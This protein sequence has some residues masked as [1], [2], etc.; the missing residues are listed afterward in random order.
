LTNTPSDTLWFEQASECWGEFLETG[1]V[2]SLDLLVG[3]DGVLK[4]AFGENNSNPS[5][6]GERHAGST[7]L[8]ID[9]D[10]DNDQDLLMG[11]ISF[12]N[13]IYLEND[14]NADFAL[15]ME[16]EQHFPKNNTPV[17]IS[18]FPAAYAVDVNQDGLEDLLVAANEPTA[19]QTQDQIW[20][21]ANTGDLGKPKFE[22]QNL[23]FLSEEMIDV[24]EGAYPAFVDYNQ[25]GLLDLAIGNY[26]YFYPET[27]TSVS[28]LTL[29]ENVGTASEAIFELVDKDYNNLSSLNLSGLFPTFGDVDG[30]G[31][32]DM[33]AGDVVGRMHYFENTANTGEIMQLTLSQ[34]NFLE[35]PSGN[36][37]TPY[38][39]D[40]N[41]DGKL[42]LVV[43]EMAGKLNYFEHS[44]SNEILDFTLQSNFFGEVDVRQIGFPFGYSVPVLWQLP[45]TDE[46]SLLVH[47]ENGQV[48]W[49][50]DLAETAFTLQNNFVAEIDD[51]GRGGMAMADLNGDGLVELIVGNRSG[52][53]QLWEQKITNL[54]PTVPIDSLQFPFRLYPN[55]SSEYLY[56]EAFPNSILQSETPNVVQITVYDVLGRLVLKPIVV[57]N[58]D[59]YTIQ[60]LSVHHWNTGIYFLDVQIGT[61]QWVK[62]VIVQP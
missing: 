32:A 30:D 61:Q 27:N 40:L 21:Y 59:W 11:D 38:L 15:V 53:L 17:H 26:R 6:Q 52:G 57:E 51:G 12:S 37:A 39:F 46:P 5:L 54:P 1:A 18:I 42:D 19:S 10:L 14:G 47:G 55:P 24:G 31:D 50:T 23:N 8:A 29:F 45:E 41:Q 60:K 49:Y 56:F 33:I 7:L 13:L 34:F 16:Q 20:Y 3:C 43:G 25:D 28:S 2:D 9:W 35:V 22:L 48:S 36:W 62:K 58:V 44:N 4:T